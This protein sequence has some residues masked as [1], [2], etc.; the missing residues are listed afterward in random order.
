[1]PISPLEREPTS[2]TYLAQ[3][4]LPNPN[5]INVYGADARCRTFAQTATYHVTTM[6]A[7]AR[8][9]LMASCYLRNKMASIEND[10][11]VEIQDVGDD[12]L[13]Q[14]V[15]VQDVPV[16]VIDD[17]SEGIEMAQPL[18]I[19]HALPDQF[20]DE[21]ELQTAEEIIEDDGSCHFVTDEYQDHIPNVS[22]AE[23]GLEVFTGYTPPAPV[24]TIPQS[25]GRRGKGKGKRAAKGNRFP[26]QNDGELTLEDMQ[27][28]DP[29]GSRKWERKQVQIKTLDGEFSVTMWASGLLKTYKNIRR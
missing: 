1:M 9:Q 27:A 12:V 16:E 7:G 15:E 20:N 25:G 21:I 2:E 14:E 4:S 24:V 5:T 17:P 6:G 19:L 11:E 28:L 26:Q 23:L 29:S 13:V 18:I 8:D 3:C 22:E 10:C